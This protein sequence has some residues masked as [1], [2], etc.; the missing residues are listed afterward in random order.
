MRVDAIWVAIHH[1]HP[2]VFY[3]WKIIS[4]KHDVNFDKRVSMVLGWNANVKS[5][6]KYISSQRT[7]LNGLLTWSQWAGISSQRA[8][9]KG[10]IEFQ[11]SDYTFNRNTVF[12][13]SCWDIWHYW[14]PTSD[15]A[16]MQVQFFPYKGLYYTITHHKRITS[17]YQDN[18]SLSCKYERLSSILH[19]RQKYRQTNHGN[20]PAA[21]SSPAIYGEI[22]CLSACQA[23]YLY[24]PDLCSPGTDN[25]QIMEA[26]AI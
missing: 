12:K 25:Y 4:Y 2:V 26:N 18:A 15:T 20:A 7:C 11:P 14:Q 5:V 6:G 8:F 24:G 3:I 16:I 21:D 9:L 22:L 17:R 10:A 13:Q 19:N 23:L 1:H